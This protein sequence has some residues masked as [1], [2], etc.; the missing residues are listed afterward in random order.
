VS[1]RELDAAFGGGRPAAAGVDLPRRL[2]GSAALEQNADGVQL[3]IDGGAVVD[4]PR[5]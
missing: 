4:G 3:T 2:R 5:T 1:R